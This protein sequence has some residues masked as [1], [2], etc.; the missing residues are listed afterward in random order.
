[1]I[2]NGALP[3]VW[4]MW[5]CIWQNKFKNHMVWRDTAKIHKII[6]YLVFLFIAACQS[7][8]TIIEKDLDFIKNEIQNNHPGIYNDSDPD[9]K[10]KLDIHCNKAFQK[11]ATIENCVLHKKYILENFI[12][13]FNDSHVYIHWYDEITEKNNYEFSITELYSETIWI[14][15]PTFEMSKTQQSDFQKILKNLPKHRKKQRIIFDLRHN[16]G[17]N[18]DYGSNII[19]NLFGKEKGEANRR[20][21][22]KNVYVEWRASKDN[23]KHINELI[24]NQPSEWLSV[25]AKG[26]ENSLKIEQ[27]YY[28]EAFKPKDIHSATLNYETVNAKIYVIIQNCNVS[29][30]LDFIDELKLIHKN[31][32]LAGERTKSD[33][34]YMEI[35]ETKLPSGLGSFYFPIK[36]YRNRLRPAHYAYNPDIILEK[37]TLDSVNMIDGVNCLLEKI[38]N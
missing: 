36:V 38:K 32:T 31:V 27:P 33:T 5:H 4:L 19:D 18:S 35:R 3:T 2:T 25:A 16:S 12:K 30:A 34:D 17:G 21:L 15:L 9:F 22:N 8:K 7:D 6:K 14:T 1:M 28:K 13:S 29:A 10:Q 37:D 20:K 26:I 11:I 24:K 23:L